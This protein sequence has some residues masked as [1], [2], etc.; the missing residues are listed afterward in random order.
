MK[1]DREAM[2]KP[3]NAKSRQAAEAARVAPVRERNSRKG[4]ARQAESGQ[5]KGGGPKTK[6]GKAIVSRNAVKHGIMSE[7][8]VIPGMEEVEDWHAHLDGVIKSLE[9]EGH[10]E[11]VL[12]ER[13]ASLFWRFNRVIRYETAI[14]ARVIAFMTGFGIAGSDAED[15]ETLADDA[16]EEVPEE[17]IA[18]EAE[19][20]L[21]PTNFHL[22]RIMRYETH[23]HRQLQQTSNQLE[24]IQARRHGQPS[25]L[26]RVDFSSSPQFRNTRAPQL[27]D[28]LPGSD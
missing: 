24:A 7:T 19:T 25:N 14:T 3:K 28:V 10:L 6:V 4:S 26:T 20:H 5:G 22:D 27:S 15:E 16:L 13:I 12:A 1:D 18:A 8:P 23:I 9:P 17:A 21:L 2:T 11:T